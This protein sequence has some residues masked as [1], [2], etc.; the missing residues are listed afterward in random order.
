MAGVFHRRQLQMIAQW[1]T[2]VFVPRKYPHGC[3]PAVRTL[4]APFSWQLCP[5][6]ILRRGGL[7]SLDQ[8]RPF[9]DIHR[10]P[11]G[12]AHRV[13]TPMDCSRRHTRRY[14]ARKP[15]KP[16]TW[17]ARS[18]LWNEQPASRM[19]V[20][21]SRTRIL[22]R[23]HGRE[24][25]VSLRWAYSPLRSLFASHRPPHRVNGSSGLS[26]ATLATAPSVPKAPIAPQ[27]QVR[28]TDSCNPHLLFSKTK[29]CVSCGYRITA[30]DKPS[31]HR[32]TSRVHAE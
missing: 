19:P 22:R 11:A 7:S 16:G 13:P 8:C 14:T 29:T 15:T 31:A 1:R 27:A 6:R 3:S 24:P 9:S 17:H 5:L 25:K 32:R 4:L 12:T 26:L 23:T 28:L 30:R 18:C 21:V 10:R 2:L 20:A